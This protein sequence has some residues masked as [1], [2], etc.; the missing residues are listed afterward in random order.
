[1]KLQWQ[2]SF[3]HV[4][5]QFSIYTHI[6]RLLSAMYKQLSTATCE[7]LKKYFILLEFFPFHNF[8]F[9]FSQVWSNQLTVDIEVQ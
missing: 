9:H 2:V 6:L 7:H 1:M 3:V 8:P 5:S 4:S